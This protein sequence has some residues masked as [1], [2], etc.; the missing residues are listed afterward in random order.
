MAW[1]VDLTDV[2]LFVA[3][4]AQAFLCPFTKV[5]ESFNLQAI[6]DVLYHRENIS[7]VSQV[8]LLIKVL[9]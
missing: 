4:A 9:T 7:Q 5:E 3:M 6:H 2:L 8:W 1:P